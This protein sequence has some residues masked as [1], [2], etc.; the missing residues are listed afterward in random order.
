MGWLGRTI[1]GYILWTYERGS[2]H[3]DIMVTLILLFIFLA[4]LRMNFKDKPL[5][6]TARQTGVLVTQD[7]PNIVYQ[8]DAAARDER[9]QL[10]VAENNPEDGLHRVIEEIAGEVEILH[11]ERVTDR[12]GKVVAYKAWVRRR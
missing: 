6:R 8:V 10:I 3:Y 9:G 12:G 1:R 7:G 5:E 11:Y 4:P 2:L